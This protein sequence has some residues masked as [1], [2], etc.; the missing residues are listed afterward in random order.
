M[1]MKKLLRRFG[2]PAAPEDTLSKINAQLEFKKSEALSLGIECEFGL[3]NARD[4]TPVGAA[5]DIVSRIGDASV[6][7]EI[8]SH[9][10]E[11]TTGTCSSIQEAEFDLA[12]AI[13]LL[14]PHLQRHDAELVGA[15][16]LPLLKL[17]DA[18]PVETPRYQMLRETRQHMCQ[19]F[20]TLGMHIHLGMRDALSCI[21]YHNF[22]MRFLPH[23]LA[24][25]ANSP[26]EEGRD[27]GFDSIRP[28]VTESIPTGGPPYYF[29][30]WHDYQN[31]CR[32]LARSRS[33]T[34]LKDLWWDLRPCPRYGT[35]EIR[36]CDQPS[37]LAEVAAVGA[38]VHCLG[39]W[40]AEHQ[41]W[42]EEMPRPSAWLMRENKWRAMRY[43]LDADIV[44]NNTGDTRALKDDILQWLER[45][46]PVFE[47]R[48]YQPYRET[49]LDIVQNGNGAARQ[50]RIWKATGSLEAVYARA[51]EE[52]KRGLPMWDDP[53]PPKAGLAEAEPVSHHY[54]HHMAQ[55]IGVWW[56]S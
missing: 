32:A 50:R 40:F 13:R 10:I 44:I 5:P 28:S 43:G 47:S 45:L 15:G 29:S 2:K 16:S 8:F 54:H 39:L 49:L 36:I 18:Q 42:M 23:M 33:I 38:F 31:L 52:R 26:F 53:A 55:G 11:V 46:R 48:Q 14:E 41:D 20:T 3:V 9:M 34:D 25:S 4:F 17:G 27:T 35:L 22:Y 37:T 1:L 6:Q 56:L 24:L 12:A 51:I 21:R 19:R 7:Q 30:S